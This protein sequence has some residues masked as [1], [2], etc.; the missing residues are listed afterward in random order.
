[1]KIS[2]LGEAIMMSVSYAYVIWK[3]FYIIVYFTQINHKII[4]W[5]SN[6]EGPGFFLND[7]LFYFIFS[8]NFLYC[9]EWIHLFLYSILQN[10]YVDLNLLLLRR[11]NYHFFMSTYLH[12]YRSILRSDVGN[13]N[14]E[15]EAGFL[16]LSMIR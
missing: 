7:V 1:M 9:V 16:G 4:V 12:L 15:G 3:H 8:T 6:Y 13:G 10:I 11:S 5:Y 2:L 14:P